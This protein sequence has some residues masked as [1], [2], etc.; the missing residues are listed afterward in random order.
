MIV[1]R[2][3]RESDLDS[4]LRLSHIPGMFNLPGDPDTLRDR[5]VKSVESFKGQTRGLSDS[6]YTFIAR[7]FILIGLKCGT[8]LGN[9]ANVKLQI[10]CCDGA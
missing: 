6:K 5:I 3:A 9:I 2:G 1:L 8:I 10:Q 4:L 7:D